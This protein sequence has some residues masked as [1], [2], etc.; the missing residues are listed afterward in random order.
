MSRLDALAISPAVW[1]A[2]FAL[3]VLL[4]RNTLATDVGMVG[5]VVG[6]ELFLTLGGFLLTIAQLPLLI[7]AVSKGRKQLACLA[8]LGVVLWVVFWLCGMALTPSMVYVT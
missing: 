5:F 8:A 2:A 7:F 1:G 6:V 3:F 4:T